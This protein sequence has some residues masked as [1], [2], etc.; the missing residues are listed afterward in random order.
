MALALVVA[1]PTT[2]SAAGA[3]APPSSVPPPSTVVRQTTGLDVSNDGGLVAFTDF[4]DTRLAVHEIPASAL[5]DAGNGG[6]APTR[7]KLIKK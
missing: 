3:P 6:L 1:A 5:L 2:I 4:L 7:G